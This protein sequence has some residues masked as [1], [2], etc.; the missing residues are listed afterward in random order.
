[1]RKFVITCLLSAFGF[2]SANVFA[3]FVHPM[4]FKG[5]DGEKNEVL[6]YI[7]ERVKHDYCDSG[8]DMCQEATLR[9]MEQQ[10]LNAFKK[11]SKATDRKIM[12]KVIV[13]YCQSGLDMCS[14]HTISMMYDQNYNASKQETKW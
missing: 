11:A 8:L 3:G 5:S 4:D 6:N 2:F 14:Y 9:M 12:D 13:D 1:M 10:N 7:K